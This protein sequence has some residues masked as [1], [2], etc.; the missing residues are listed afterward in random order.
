MV[1]WGLLQKGGGN[2]SECQSGARNSLAWII[3]AGGK[4]D[5]ALILPI[6]SS[7][8]VTLHQD[9]VTALHRHCA[10]MARMGWLLVGTIAGLCPSNSFWTAQHTVPS[11]L[12]PHTNSRSHRASFLPKILYSGG[13]RCPRSCCG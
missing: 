6:N 10:L 4:R 8:S 11:P 1:V 5:E 9:Q 7:L 12:H 13:T 2:F 3:V